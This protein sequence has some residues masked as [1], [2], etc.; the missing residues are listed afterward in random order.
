MQSFPLADEGVFPEVLLSY[1]SHCVNRSIGVTEDPI[2]PFLPNMPTYMGSNE[3]PKKSDRR[4]S[5]GAFPVADKL[6]QVFQE[7]PS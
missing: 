3:S 6:L 5:G 7:C 1:V 2:I 4:V